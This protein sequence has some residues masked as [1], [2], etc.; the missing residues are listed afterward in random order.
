M[1]ASVSF[2]TVYHICEE[3][4]RMKNVKMTLS[5]VAVVL[6]VAAGQVSAADFYDGGTHNINYQLDWVNVDFGSTGIGKHTV[7]NLLPGSSI[8]LYL[9]TYNSG[10]AN[11]YDVPVGL[12]VQTH[13]SSQINMY[14]G[15]IS[16]YVQTHDSSHMNIYGGSTSLYFRVYESSQ[17][18]ISGGSINSDLKAM[19]NSRV[20]MSGG[21]VIGSL[22]ATQSS[23]ITIIGS[24][25][26]ID[27]SLVGFGQ[28][29]ASDYVSGRLT[30]KLANG[31]IIN[32]NFSIGDSASFVFVPEPST[33]ILLGI[34]AISLLAYGWRRRISL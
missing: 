26:A 23:Q 16:S 20:T 22:S 30:G 31:D 3:E 9:Q 25:F 11:I 34:G 21:S 19:D 2:K 17:V 4:R 32:N 13:D 28:Y 12:Y 33:L 1:T 29:F 7:V 10:Q 8:Q 27:G 14:D 18:N 15:S 24:N 6:F 5:M